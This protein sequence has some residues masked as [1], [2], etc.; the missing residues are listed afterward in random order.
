[1]TS[2]SGDS[3]VPSKAL[4]SH[5]QPLSTWWRAPRV[6]VTLGGCS[7]PDSHSR[8]CNRRQQSFR[9]RCVTSKRFSLYFTPHHLGLAPGG[10]RA[11]GPASPSQEPGQR[12]LLPVGRVVLEGGQLHQGCG[13]HQRFRDRHSVSPGTAVSADD[14]WPRPRVSRQ[15]GWR[16]ARWA[17]GRHGTRGPREGQGAA[18]PSS[19]VTCAV[20][21]VTVPAG[22]VHPVPRP[23]PASGA[24]GAQTLPGGPG[25]RAQP[26]EP[27]GRR[28]HQSP[29]RRCQPG[30]RCQPVPRGLAL[31][32]AWAHRLLP[33]ARSR[34]KRTGK[35]HAQPR[36]EGVRA[37]GSLRFAVKDL[38]C[39]G[40]RGHP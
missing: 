26:K 6:H 31:R 38:G 24:A 32:H 11:G 17:S 3:S 14:L 23:P 33:L 30:S 39:R 7:S 20:R 40:W 1:M 22:W 10:P 27:G 2:P 12:R 5:R 15:R 37:Q 9:N 4:P 16:G 19:D 21:A 29:S 34:P 36:P 35:S 8:G 13:S 18:R 28:D 25:G